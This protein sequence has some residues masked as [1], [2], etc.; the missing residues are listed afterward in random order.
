MTRSDQIKDLFVQHELKDALTALSEES[1]GTRSKYEQ[2]S[3]LF[4]ANYHGLEKEIRQGTISSENRQIQTNSLIHRATGLLEDLEEEYPIKLKREVI[5]D[6]G[7]DEAEID[8]EGVNL[9][10]RPLKAFVSY[11]HVDRQFQEQ[12]GKYL[13]LMEMDEIIDSWVDAE[14]VAG[15]DWDK[16][17]KGHLEEAEVIFLLISIDFLT[18]KYIRKH[19][20]STAMRKHE[21]K[22]ARVIPI[23]IRE[24]PWKKREFAKLQAA[25]TT[26][27][28][29]PVNDKA[30]NEIDSEIRR[31]LAKFQGR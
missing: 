14:I 3:V 22:T 7:E 20:L 9:P 5:V 30:W 4:L 15:E 6:E 2:A 12:F 21:A 27:V 31:S 17:I 10:P 16:Q 8:E 24:C 29:T 11:A 1:K 25:N 26:P 19:E 18:S 28:S 23:I 13:Q